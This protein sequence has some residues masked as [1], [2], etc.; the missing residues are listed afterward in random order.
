MKK[1]LKAMA[2]V[3][4]LAM[5]FGITSCSKSVAKDFVKI[6]GTTVTKKVA[7]SEVFIE[8]RTLEINTFY[9]CDHEVTQAEY[10]QIIGSNPSKF[11]ENP[12]EAET[13]ENRPVE[14]VSYYDALIYCNKRSMTEKLTPCYTINGSTDPSDWGEQYEDA[15]G[16]S[17]VKCDFN[18]N[19]YRLPTEVEWEYAARGGSNLETYTYAGS[20]K[21]EELAWYK[22]N[23]GRKTHEVKKQAASSLGLYD[24]SGNVWEWC[25][26]WYDGIDSSTE[27]TG[28]TTEFVRVVRGGSWS[29]RVSYSTVSYRDGNYPYDY[30]N[31]L[32]F[33]VVRTAK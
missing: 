1:M 28:S 23:S 27:I 18:A 3:A 16:Y 19:G 24:M 26:D 20:D 32:G 7:D 8:G 11:L 22:D 2:L 5:M 17:T 15:E 21:I 9:M 10:E 31:Y 14:C 13:Q 12:A 30:C 33:R 29:D 4:A 6:T 25:Y